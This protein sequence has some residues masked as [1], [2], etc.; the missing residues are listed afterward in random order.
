VR[1]KFSAHA[2]IIKG[3]DSETTPVKINPAYESIFASEDI[4][5]T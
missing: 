1:R 4:V 5:L 2:H 3:V